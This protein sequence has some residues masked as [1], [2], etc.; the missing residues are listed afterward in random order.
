[1][2]HQRPHLKI[3]Y[4]LGA[5]LGC[6]LRSNNVTFL[7]HE[8]QVEQELLTLPEH[9]C[10][11]PLQSGVPIPRSSFFSVIFCRSLFV[12]FSFGHCVVC[13]SSILRLLITPLVSSNFSLEELCIIYHTAYEVVKTV[14]LSQNR[15]IKATLQKQ[16]SEFH[17]PMIN[18]PN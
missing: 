6:H 18:C 10:S 2:V 5:P 11:L 15:S 9:L 1:M 14:I 12:L 8:S 13:T 3:Y 17:C 7:I 4:S 16:K